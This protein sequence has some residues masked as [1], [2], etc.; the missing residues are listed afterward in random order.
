MK[1]FAAAAV[2]GA[3]VVGALVVPAVLSNAQ[4]AR[5]QAQSTLVAT[6]DLSPIQTELAALRAEMAALRQAVT[7]P[8][9]L[10]EEVAQTA[11][12]TKAL[13]A[14]LAELADLIGKR[15]DSLR[16]ALAALDPSTVWEYQCLRSRSET[17]A[18][19]LA[20]EGWQLVTASNDWLYFRRP[21]V[22]GRRTERPPEG[23]KEE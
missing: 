4:E 16:P 9:G 7:D 8:K 1:P 21:L 6:I 22:A 15:F 20:R 18:N 11:A 10:R 14:R 13:D 12:A 3:V 17:V 2:A 19:R 23:E 5:Q